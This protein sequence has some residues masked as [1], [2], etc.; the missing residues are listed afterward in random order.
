MNL[1]DQ[2]PDLGNVVD[3]V[4]GMRVD[5]AVAVSRNL[6]S[7]HDGRDLYFCGRGCKLE[8][9]EDP[10]RFLGPDYQPSM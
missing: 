8:F 10:E 7:E 1:V 4:C 3:P 6:H 2:A 5:P 9:D